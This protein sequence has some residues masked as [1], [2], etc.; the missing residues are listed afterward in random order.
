M[1]TNPFADMGFLG[2]LGVTLQGTAD[3]TYM[4][5][6]RKQQADS[7]FRNS[8]LE[9]GQQRI[10]LSRDQVEAARQERMEQDIRRNRQREALGDLSRAAALNAGA[11][12]ADNVQAYLQSGGD[13][14]ALG[15]LQKALTPVQQEMVQVYDPT[16]GGMVYVPK[17]Q[18]LG[19]LASAPKQQERRI[20][21]QD[22]VQY[23]ADTGEPVI[24]T[25]SIPKPKL[26]ENLSEGE[27][28][29]DKAFA[30]EYVAL[31]A[32]GGL[33]DIDKLVEQ[34]NDSL[35]ALRSGEDITG[36]WTG[37]IPEFAEAAIIPSSVAAREAVEEVA[38]RNLR[39]VL[40]GQ[41]AQK[42]GEQLI[43]RAY[44]PK[45][46]EEENAKRV[47]RLIE[48]I[49]SAVAQKR[50]AIDYFKKKGTL[51]GWQGKLPSPSDIDVAKQSPSELSDAELEAI[52]YGN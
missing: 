29:T 13:P 33:A 18:A 44:N 16:R 49:K 40:G 11:L 14:A 45:L 22:G 35:S 15:Q 38:Q 37:L 12:P 19:S 32:S 6:L 43:R 46:S 26:S 24:P 10:D 50:S 20:V 36:A 23:Y 3:P 39:E 7:A 51:K 1:T 21:E 42:E 4:Q 48:Q 2:K 27:K 31:E 5:R 34:L 25:T 8:Q 17:S 41:F 30:K 52:A 28:A 47:G 9:Q